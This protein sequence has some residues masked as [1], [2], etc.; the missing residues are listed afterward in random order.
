MGYT[1]RFSRRECVERKHA[2]ETAEMG[3]FQSAR[4]IFVACNRENTRAP[5]Y[6]TTI[7]FDFMAVQQRFRFFVLSVDA[8]DAT[9]VTN[10]HMF[11]VL[12]MMPTNMPQ[13]DAYRTQTDNAIFS[14]PSPHTHT[15]PDCSNDSNTFATNNIHTTQFIEM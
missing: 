8:D 2:D 3:I 6:R 14:G 13:Y 4:R 15:R 9:H 10:S 11:D 12:F 7:S 1:I 5:K